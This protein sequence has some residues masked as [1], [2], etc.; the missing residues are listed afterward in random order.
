MRL[1]T[2]WSACV[3]MVRAALS[4][5]FEVRAART[6]NR[7]TGSVTARCSCALSRTP[8]TGRP[9]SS[10]LP[11]AVRSATSRRSCSS[12]PR[13]VGALAHH[14]LGVHAAQVVPRH[15]A[16]QLIATRTQAHRQL[17]HLAPFGRLEDAGRRAVEGF[18]VDRQAVSPEGQP[19]AACSND[20]ELVG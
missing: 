1:L 2:L 16:D 13:T 3:A 19:P 20:D 11:V 8:V 17:A 14:Q 12:S 6:R 5:T 9:A 4:E 7:W 18:L 10:V 15:V